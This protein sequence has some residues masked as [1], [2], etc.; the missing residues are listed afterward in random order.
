MRQDRDPPAGRLQGPEEA[1]LSQLTLLESLDAASAALT[2][3]DPGDSALAALSPSERRAAHDRAVRIQDQL[4]SLLSALVRGMADDGAD[5]VDP[6]GVP[7]D[8]ALPAEDP[9]SSETEPPRS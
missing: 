6:R 7:K 1:R 8:Y 2:A 9:Y 5:L 3:A 4:V